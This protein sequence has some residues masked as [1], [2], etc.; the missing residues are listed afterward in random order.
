MIFRN[1]TERTYRLTLIA[2]E[3]STSRGE[4]CDSPGRVPQHEQRVDDEPRNAEAAQHDN[5]SE[6]GRPNDR[7][8]DRLRE[9]GRENREL[10]RGG[11][12]RILPV[13]RGQAR[14]L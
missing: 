3:A 8:F 12:S 11:R 10:R 1:T 4:Q 5:E 13:L 6:N 7:L 2:A 14:S 9:V